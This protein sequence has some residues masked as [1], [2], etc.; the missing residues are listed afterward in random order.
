MRFEIMVALRQDVKGE[1]KMMRI[2]FRIAGIIGKDKSDPESKR[3]F[4][5]VVQHWATGDDPEKD[6]YQVMETLQRRNDDID[7]HVSLVEAIENNWHYKKR[8]HQDATKVVI[9]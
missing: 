9:I 2:E 7:D 1:H 4:A 5:E 6:Y 3:Q 8:L